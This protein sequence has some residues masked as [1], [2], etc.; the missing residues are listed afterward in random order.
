[1]PDQLQ[2][3]FAA[4][5][6]ALRAIRAGELD[7]ADAALGELRTAY[8]GLAS[9]ERAAM[10]P[11]AQHLRAR[12]DEARRTHSGA[13]HDPDALLGSLGLTAYRAG[14]REVV[15]AALQ[16]RDALV[17]MPTGGGKSACYQ[18]PG[19]AL[20]GLT[21]VISPLIALMRDQHDRLAEAGHPVAML[22]SSQT[23]DANRDALSRVRGGAV[24]ILFAAPERFASEA[25]VSALKTQRLRLVAVDEAHCV[26]EWGHDFREDYLRLGDTLK[27]LGSP[28]T[29][30]LTATATPQVAAEISRRLGLRDPVVVRRPFDRPNLTFDVIA[31]NGKGARA[32]KL[33]VLASG[34]RRDDMRPAIVYCG[35]RDDTDT[36]A[37]ELTALGIPTLA[38]HAGMTAGRDEAQEAF[39]RG[40]VDVITATV[41]FGMGIDKADVRS[42]WH[43]AIPTSLEGYYQEA[44]RAGRD[45]QPARAVLLA[46]RA[47]L[48]RLQRIIE[49]KSGPARNAAWEGYHAIVSLSEGDG[50]R[51]DR[52][53]QHFG[54]DQAPA[55]TVR[56]CDVCGPP[57]W[58]DAAALTAPSRIASGGRGAVPQIDLNTEDELLFEQLRGWRRERA[59]GKP[60]Y[61][62]CAD[63]T[64]KEVAARRPSTSE[65]LAAIKGVGPHFLETHA[66]SL[67]DLVAGRS[68]VAAGS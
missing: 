31:L 56:C 8:A 52:I 18:L 44:G 4:M 22:A 60:A 7:A 16:G 68:R 43:W 1:M 59:D 45:R 38:Y 26:V 66:A 14:Q 37:A 49:R 13:T 15:E 23:L 10:L 25:F 41:A 50:C 19:L 58:L 47:D 9:D 61:T 42:V 48:G 53:L 28:P 63:F 2:L 21:V 54:D 51:R 5:E 29:M 55:P 32:R 35:T 64:L 57:E 24:R 62:V 30:A 40:E 12:L 46:M 33:S 17:V 65:E 11:L 39:M 20:D 3:P 67:L 34:L 27:M 36:V 6:R